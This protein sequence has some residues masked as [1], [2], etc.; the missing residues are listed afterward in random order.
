MITSFFCVSKLYTFWTFKISQKLFSAEP[1]LIGGCVN[2]PSQN[3]DYEHDVWPRLIG[4]IK[5][6]SNQASVDPRVHF[7]VSF[8]CCLKFQIQISWSSWGLALIHLKPLKPC[9]YVAFL[10]DCDFA[11]FLS[12]SKAQKPV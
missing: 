5:N 6:W 7:F 8:L 4:Q 10:V 11:P 12:D 2:V 3:I 1:V 9:F